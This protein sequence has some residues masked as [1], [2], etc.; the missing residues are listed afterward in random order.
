MSDSNS[1]EQPQKPNGDPE[2]SAAT[3]STSQFDK[4]I[5]VVEKLNVTMEGQKS[6]MEKVESTLVDHGKK[7]DILTR[8]ALKSE[9]ERKASEATLICRCRRS[10]V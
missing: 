1:S 3:L 9:L 5:A 2:T 6:T 7:F 8:D 10:A 4:L